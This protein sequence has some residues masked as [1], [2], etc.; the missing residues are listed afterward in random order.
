MREPILSQTQSFNRSR[1]RTLTAST[2]LAAA[3]ALVAAPAWA[4]PDGTDA[5]SA[6]DDEWDV[7]L[8]AGALIAPAYEGADEFEVYPIPLVSIIWNDRVFLDIEHGLGVYALNSDDLKLGAS[9]GYGRGRDESDAARLRGMGDIDPAARAHVFA[10]ASVGRVDLGLDV[11]RDLG[12]SEGLQIRP[13]ASAGFKVSDSVWISPEV[14]ATWSGEAYMSTFFG[15]S[16]LQ[17]L[18]SGLPAYQADAGFRRADLRLN[19]AWR[20]NENW[21]ANANVGA[22]YMLGDAEYSPLTMDQ[23]QP[24][25]GFFLARRF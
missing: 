24:Q 14:S 6:G 4:D 23:V 5:R 7:T 1:V 12:G 17:A 18:G 8:G 9:V 16:P 15:V 22:G 11:S 20:I 2:L 25:A 13:S 19:V 10:E 3:L 21:F